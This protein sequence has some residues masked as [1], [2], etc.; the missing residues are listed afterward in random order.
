MASQSLP[1]VAASAP[2]RGNRT[3]DQQLDALNK[4]SLY[5]PR[6]T[7]ILQSN[8]KQLRE[9]QADRARS[10]DYAMRET[11][12]IAKSFAAKQTV[13]DPTG[14]GFVPANRARRTADSRSNGIIK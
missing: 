1:R 2:L 8:L 3:P 4:Y 12:Q 14:D 5:K 10:E 6:L 11:A 9:I 7:R 13:Y